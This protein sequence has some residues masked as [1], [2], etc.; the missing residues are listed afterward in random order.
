MY[1]NP[2]YQHDFPDPFVFKFCGEYWAICTGYWHDGGV[3]GLLHSRDLVNWKD[4]GSALNPPPFDAPCYWA[5]EIFYDNGKF[6]LYYSVGNEENMEIRVAVSDT[7]AGKYTDAGY[8]L[9]TEQFAI[10][11]H[12]FVDED[13]SRWLFYAADFLEHTH[14]GTGTVRD[15]MLSPFELEG[16]PQPISRARYDWQVYDPVRANKGNVRWHTIEGSF[17]LK[18]KDVYYQMFSGGNWQN[19]TYGVSFATTRDFLNPEEWQQFS[20]GEKILPILI[21]IPGKVIGPGHNSVVRGTDNF[22]LFCVYHRWAED[23][24]GRLLAMD[25]ME[26]VGERMLILGASSELQNLPNPPT[27]FDFFDQDSASGLS[28]NWICDDDENW[29]VN[30]NAAVSNQAAEKA[31]AVCRIESNCFLVEVSSKALSFEEKES[32]YGFSLFQNQ[33]VA[34]RCLILPLTKQVE[35]SSG[36]E[37][38][39]FDLPVDFNPLSFHLWRVEVD[40]FF[41]KIKLDE[42]NFIFNEQLP[43]AAENFALYSRKMSAAFAGFALTA[44]FEELFERSN[45]DLTK[46]GWKIEKGLFDFWEISNNCL[47]FAASNGEKSVLLKEFLLENFEFVAN[48]RFNNRTTPEA[49]CGFYFKQ[50]EAEIVL[51]IEQ[52][53]AKYFLQILTENG[54]RQIALPDNFA[55]EEYQH[56][57]FRREGET[58]KMQCETTELGSLSISAGQIRAGFYARQIQSEIEMARITLI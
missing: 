20:D 12:V 2:L 37:T 51:T 14:V 21:T 24:R 42:A 32:C 55:P 26:F 31:Q 36:N 49:V 45:A 54:R 27:F 11:P 41:V 30:S 43:V 5:P 6:Y 10:D 3:L 50:D 34:L 53:D 1:L 46:L 48:I 13:N 8:R 16:K 33:T 9:T 52:S 57:R 7:P 17:V 40:N 35:I 39:T 29:L 25:R 18:R 58:I 4:R 44:G 15:R 38:R 19:P 28:E 47:K 56:F 23:L 22:Q